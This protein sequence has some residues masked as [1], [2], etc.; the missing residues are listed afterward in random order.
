MNKIL[1]ITCKE[2]TYLISKKEDGDIGLINR[3]KLKMHL[4]ICSVCKLFENQSWFI[5]LNA[6][7]SHEHTTTTL[8]SEAK[9]KIELAL[10]NA[11]QTVLLL[12]IFSPIFS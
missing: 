10:K 7:H 6:Q 8:S 3:L 9:E 11:Q 12:T 4:G 1:N 2:A 5:K